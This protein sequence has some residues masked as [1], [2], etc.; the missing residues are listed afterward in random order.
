MNAE[1][2]D[3]KIVDGIAVVTLGSPKRLYFDA[4][5]GDALT[6]ALETFAGDHRVRVV[7]VTGGA[8]GYFNRHFGI[9]SLI[10][11]AEDLPAS[12]PGCPENPT[13]NWASS[14]NA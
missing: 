5:M 7:I 8:P 3:T 14:A 12:G 1:I 11:I 4:E 13:S 10:R 2:L 9:P 6:G